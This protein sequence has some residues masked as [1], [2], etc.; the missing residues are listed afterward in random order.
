V[1]KFSNSNQRGVTTWCHVRQFFT[2]LNWSLPSLFLQIKTGFKSTLTS[3]IK[4]L[5]AIL[6]FWH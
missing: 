4:E 2:N 5:G 3:Q 6:H 1:T